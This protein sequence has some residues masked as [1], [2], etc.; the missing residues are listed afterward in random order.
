MDK[1][2][3]GRVTLLSLSS[4]Y[5]IPE[6]LTKKKISYDLYGKLVLT[7]LEKEVEDAYNNG[8]SL[9]F[10]DSPIQHPF[11]CDGFIEEGFLLR[12]L[13]EYKFDEMLSNPVARARVLVQVLFYMK[14]FEIGGLALPNVIMI[15]DRNECFVIHSNDIVNYLDEETVWETAPSEAAD[16][17][18][19]MVAKIAK[20][21]NIN[22]FIFRIDKGFDITDIV[23]RIRDLSTNVKRYVRVTEHNI[24]EIFDYFVNNVFRRPETLEPHTIVEIF[25]GVLL[26]PLDYYQHPGDR[27]I[28][29]GKG[30]RYGIYG[31]AYLAFFDYYKKEYTPQEKMKFTEISDRLVEDTIRRRNGEFFTPVP[32]V[33]KA[34]RMIEKFLGETWKDDYVVWDNC[35][36]TKNLTR[37]YRFKELYC[38]TLIENDL[39]IVDHYNTEA[40]SFVFD[41]LNDP[42][43][44][45]PKKLLKAL[46]DD[47]PIVFFLNPPFATSATFTAERQK[48]DGSY[49]NMVAAEMRKEELD[50]ACRNTVPQFLYRILAIKKEFGLS[51]VKIAL[52]CKPNFLCAP[53]FDKFRTLFFKHFRYHEGIYFRA[54]EFAD[55]S[56]N[57]GI[58]F[59]LWSEGIQENRTSFPHVVV[60]NNQGR[61]EELFTKEIYNCDGVTNSSEW[62][63]EIP[64]SPIK[65]DY[66]VLT[67][68]ITVFN[69]PK[70]K[71][72]GK[73]SSNAIGCFYHVS[74]DVYHSASYVAL[75]TGNCSH[76]SGKWS[77]TKEN[78]ERVVTVFAAR[79]LVK[80]EWFNDK[81]I[82]LAPD[83]NHPDWEEF[84]SDSIVFSLFHSASNQT[85]M[86]DVFYAGEKYDIRNEFFFM[87]RSEL[88]EL[89]NT[90]SNM[91]CYQDARTDKDRYIYELLTNISLSNEAKSVLEDARALVRS[92]FKYREVFHLEHPEFQ[93]NNWDAGWYQ[94]KAILNKYDRKGLLEFQKRFR[95]LANKMYPKVYTLGFLK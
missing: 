1:E 24:A 94:I 18:P 74:C 27:N 12:L 90:N 41:F 91:A 76:P 93:I 58:A 4:A 7:S 13:I 67:S 55:V 10:P 17:N 34:H 15:G 81:D 51:N 19:L 42:L 2:R 84:V 21:D 63:R 43:T 92:S 33:D 3:A 8:I 61:I 39:R 79:K 28:L 73:L 22:P 89:A 23:N 5:G 78:L 31:D 52:F 36:G 35:C 46:M 30:A 14:R 53:S 54:S 72:I 16:A 83:L 71:S 48:E 66:P 49:D 38:S 86:R 64:V 70:N 29:V 50:L 45:L 25:I 65:K 88:M 80:D 95:E 20:D 62:I 57:W 32:F 77:I 47:R 69:N 26:S 60:A 85:S 40:E 82:F 11:N 59:E 56:E 87:S 75:L 9:F 6:T 44:L 37:D 68:G